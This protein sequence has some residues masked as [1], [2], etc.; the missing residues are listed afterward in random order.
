[1]LLQLEG[2]GPRMRKLVSVLGILLL[3]AFGLEQAIHSHPQPSPTEGSHCAICVV[4]HAPATVTAP[5]FVPA[6]VIINAHLVLFEPLA[7]DSVTPR[8]LYIRPPPLTA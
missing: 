5:T 1:M 4:A 8:S 6:L 3:L 2:D 7:H